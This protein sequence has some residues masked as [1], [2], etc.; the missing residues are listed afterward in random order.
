MLTYAIF[1]RA[2]YL[3]IY[4]YEKREREFVD[5]EYFATVTH[6]NAEAVYRLLFVGM[7]DHSE[8]Q[9]V[10]DEHVRAGWRPRKCGAQNSR[11][12]RT[13]AAHVHSNV[14]C[15][16]HDLVCSPSALHCSQC[17]PCSLKCA[18]CNP[19]TC[20]VSGARAWQCTASTHSGKTVS[21]CDLCALWSGART[22]MQMCGWPLLSICTRHAS[23]A[24]RMCVW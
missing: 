10:G 1:E 23:T 21:A 17:S 18:A 11:D 24:V 13:C 7:R 20:C 8:N 5:F 19:C 9:P 16:A 4:I 2:V 22:L 6:N 14:L 15:G 3:S 12:G